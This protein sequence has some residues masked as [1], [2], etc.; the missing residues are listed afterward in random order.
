MSSPPSRCECKASEEQLQRCEEE[1]TAKKMDV[2]EGGDPK[3]NSR[4]KR[5]SGGRLGQKMGIP[6]RGTPDIWARKG[7]MITPC[8]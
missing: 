5:R 3:P 1:T 4:L 2:R 8:E 7:S 6:A